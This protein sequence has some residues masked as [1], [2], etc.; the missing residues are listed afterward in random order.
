MAATAKIIDM[1]DVKDRGN[2]NPQR[3]PAGDYKV[4]VKS[5]EDHVKQGEKTSTQ[6][7][8][9][10]A[11][12]DRPR[13]TYPYYVNHT[14]AK[15]AWKV[16][17]MCIAAGLAV[18]KKRVKVDP[19]KLVGKTIGVALDDDEYEGKK[20]SVVVA[21][22]PASEVTSSPKADTPASD[23]DEPDDVDLGDDDAGDDDLDGVD[24]E[25]I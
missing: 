11:L 23:D 15:F 20:K 1:T 9:T 24:L 25:E 14:D 13:L 7:V 10:L 19:N 21:T 6:W 3:V 22:F 5:V 4:I 12:A 16:R 2:F 8:F 18:P 17:N